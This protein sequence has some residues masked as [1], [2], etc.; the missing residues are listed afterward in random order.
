MLVMFSEDTMVYPKESEWFWELQ[1]DEKTVKPL[2]ETDFYI[3][4]YIGLRKL[5]EA[6]KVQFV[7]FPGEHLQI[8]TEEVDDII[9]PFL[10]SWMSL[11]FGL[12]EIKSY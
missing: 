5:D 9:V 7:E 10:K 6:G 3:N 11:T 8:T 12:I 4:D 1:A 2:N